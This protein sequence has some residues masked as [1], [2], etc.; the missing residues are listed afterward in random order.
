MVVNL[1][2][3]AG[4]SCTADDGAIGMI[5]A[6]SHQGDFCKFA[7]NAGRQCTAMAAAAVAM[8]HLFLI[9]DW[10]TAIMDRILEDGNFIYSECIQ[11]GKRDQ[12]TGYLNIHDVP[13]IVWISNSPFKLNRN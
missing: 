7:N 4:N 2:T 11:R 10:N 9:R 3:K 5:F 13:L 6:S 1:F 8:A 12:I